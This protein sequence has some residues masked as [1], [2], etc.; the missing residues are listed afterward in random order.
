MGPKSKDDGVSTPFALLITL[1]ANGSFPNR[2]I[3][4]RMC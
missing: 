2:G 4:C 3:H 1:N